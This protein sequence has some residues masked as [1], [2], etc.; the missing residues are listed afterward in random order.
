[1]NEANR[2]KRIAIAQ[3]TLNIIEKGEYENPE[4][5]RVDVRK[6][7][8]QAIAQSTW[9][10]AD[11]F[12]P[13][14]AERDRVLQGLRKQKT[15]FEVTDETSLQA[16]QRLYARYPRMLCLN[17]ASAK[18]P[19]GGFLTGAQA[20]EESLSRA[21][22]LFPCIAQMKTMYSSNRARRTCL[23]SDDMVYSPQVPVFKDDSGALLREP[24]LLSFI[25]SPAVNAG[26]V[27]AQEKESIARI[28][29]V[30]RI[31]LGKILSIAVTKQY[32]VLILGAWG[33]GV[34]RNDPRKVA[35]YFYEALVENELFNQ[36]F[37]KVVFAV[38]SGRQPNVNMEVFVEKD[39]PKD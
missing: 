6:D 1:M 21:S 15:I 17:F 13:I 10:E 34:F 31:R 38:Y 24:Y 37:E 27:M 2:L 22:A 36:A 14:F 26:V 16:A 35:G 12:L 20:Q 28:D 8:A 29:E 33:C 11:K 4:G 3:D 39:F 9:F 18:N 7:V 23:Y 30:M 25:T 19:G 5:N 32:P